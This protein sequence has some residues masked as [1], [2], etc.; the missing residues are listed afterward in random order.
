MFMLIGSSWHLVHMFIFAGKCFWASVVFEHYVSHLHEEMPL[1]EDSTL[2]SW[3]TELSS[4]SLSY[5]DSSDW[6]AGILV[7][8]IPVHSFSWL[9]HTQVLFIPSSFWCAGALSIHHYS[10]GSLV[11]GIP[12]VPYCPF[13]E[14]P[15]CSDWVS[16]VTLLIIAPRYLPFSERKRNL[17]S[18]LSPGFA[19]DFHTWSRFR[20]E[21]F[22]KLIVTAT[23]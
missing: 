6:E 23:Q 12:P 9:F 13:K 22:S 8:W 11:Y 1:W 17:Q 2:Q 3:F 15:C 21:S 16:K 14:T 19:S 20:L 7:H 5:L 18:Q 10:F 4:L